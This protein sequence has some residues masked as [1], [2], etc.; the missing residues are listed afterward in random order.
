MIGIL[1]RTL[2]PLLHKSKDDGRRQQTKE[3]L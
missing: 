2:A 3:L 1:F